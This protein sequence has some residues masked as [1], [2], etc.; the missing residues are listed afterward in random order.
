MSDGRISYLFEPEY[1]GNRIGDAGSLVTFHLCY[2]LPEL[3][4]QWCG[5]D[6]EVFL[7]HNPTRGVIGEVSEVY[8]CSR[9]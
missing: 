5:M 6:V 4:T 2:D 9:S 3:I 7:G 1:H 8:C